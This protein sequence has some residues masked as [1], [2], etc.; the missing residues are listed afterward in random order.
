[1][2]MLSIEN[3]KNPTT[4]WKTSYFCRYLVSLNSDDE[5]TSWNIPI[6]RAKSIQRVQFHL[7]WCSFDDNLRSCSI[8]LTLMQF[9]N[10]PSRR[11]HH[12][13]WF[14]TPSSSW[15]VTLLDV[16]SQFI[17]WSAPAGVGRLGR[18]GL[19]L[20]PRWAARRYLERSAGHTNTHTIS[21]QKAISAWVTHANT[22]PHTIGG[23]DTDR[24][25]YPT[26]DWLI[27]PTG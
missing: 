1:M 16:Q 6:W 2:T 5:D 4:I 7:I 18:S 10:R 25:T 15:D 23:V 11:S 8:G 9:K 3:K 22:D 12:I 27:S 19:P 20:A 13:S 24:K 14:H 26:V 17:F 21:K